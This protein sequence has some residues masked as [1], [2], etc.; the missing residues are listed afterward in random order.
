[1]AKNNAIVK[2]NKNEMSNVEYV[3]WS[4]EDAR[5]VKKQNDKE[6]EG[7]IFRK[8]PVGKTVFRV[9][10]KM[11]GA[12]WGVGSTPYLKIWQHGLKTSDGKFIATECL[13]RG[14]P[15]SERQP[16]P[17]CNYGNELS[18][19]ANPLDQERSR[20]YWAKAVL[21]FNAVI[22]DADAEP[23]EMT[24]KMVQI[25]TGSIVKGIEALRNPPE[26][27]DADDGEVAVFG[28]F[29]NPTDKGF[30]IIVRRKGTT[31]KDTTYEVKPSA[32]KSLGAELMHLIAD[33]HDPR[34]YTRMIPA[35]VMEALLRGIDE[36]EFNSLMKK[37]GKQ[38]RAADDDD[39]EPVRSRPRTGGAA[40]R[41]RVVEDVEIDDEDE[42]D[43]ED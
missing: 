27:F 36:D 11:R 26:D 4:D 17:I 22:R 10:P 32:H 31:M 8:F 13:W 2:A 43:D 16:C 41:G 12:T 40:A 39:D 35:A 6:N 37:Q 28:D 21:L 25:G 1:M 7:V 15:V 29:S 5:E 33:Q 9:L 14:R 24:V 20:D 42:D 3:D 30:D 18:R 34:K 19:S 23:D 38:S